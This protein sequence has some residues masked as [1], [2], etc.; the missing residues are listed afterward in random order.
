MRVSVHEGVVRLSEKLF[1]LTLLLAALA[2]LSGCMMRGGSV[3]YDPQN[4]G[5]PDTSAQVVSE[6]PQR[7]APGDKLKV[8]VFQV[9]DLTGDFQVDTAGN[10]QFPLIGTVPAQGKTAVELSQLIGTRLGERYLKSPNVQVSI[11]DV[12]QQLVTVDGSVNQPGVFPVNGQTTLM[13]AVALAKGVNPDANLKRVVIFRTVNGERVAGAFDL[14]DIRRAKAR[15]PLVYGNDIII[16]DGSRA[17]ALFR[18]L[19][20]SIPL[21]GIL[22]PSY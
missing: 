11:E 2:L 5:A 18:D 19:M 17:R 6:G 8:A 4:F 20:G 1:L 9:E 7:I 10:I 14:S 21:I 12:K 13:R 15:D 16:V 3:P 22:R